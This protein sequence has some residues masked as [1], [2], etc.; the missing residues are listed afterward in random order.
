MI[1]LYADTHIWRLMRQDITKA[2]LS[3]FQ[4]REKDVAIFSCVRAKEKEKAGSKKEKKGIGFVADYR[5][6]NVAITRAK[7]SVLVC[8]LCR[9]K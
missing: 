6:M 7:S 2:S 5:R 8:N 1:V 4:G 9:L 3:S